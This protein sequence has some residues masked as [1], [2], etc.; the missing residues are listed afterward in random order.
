[1][2]RTWIIAVVAVLVFGVGG[3]FAGKAVAGGGGS[4]GGTVTV[5]SLKSMP[6][7]QVMQVFQQYLQENGG[8]QGGPG[9]LGGANGTNGANRNGGARGG[10][11][12]GT[13]V[14]KDAQSITIKS[15]N[16]ST[17]TV[18][19]TASTAVSKSQSGAIGDVSTGE[20]VMVTGSSNSDGSVTATRIQVVPADQ[21]ASIPGGPGQPPAA[22]PGTTSGS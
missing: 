20:T 11:T 21:A 2:N 14:A 6:Q 22:A 16:G 15:A 4:S 3:F 1:M 7:D 18:L 5:A 12:N 19:Y 8:F 9:G 17:R 13:V 10:F